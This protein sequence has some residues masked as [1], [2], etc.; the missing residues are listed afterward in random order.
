M[1]LS[2]LFAVLLIALTTY[3]E[4]ESVK[5]AIQPFVKIYGNYHF[6]LN[7]FSDENGFEINRAYLGFAVKLSG[8]MH[9]GIFWK[10]CTLC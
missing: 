1:K 9:K 10:I 5:P 6:G 2:I 3:A 7:E 4:D 8:R